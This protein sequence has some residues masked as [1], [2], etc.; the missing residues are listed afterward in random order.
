[1]HPEHVKAAEGVVRRE[2]MG[3]RH[4][5]VYVV[6]HDLMEWLALWSGRLGCGHGRPAWQH[7]PF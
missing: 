5:L 2:M 6:R 7:H 3:E 1:M 4:D